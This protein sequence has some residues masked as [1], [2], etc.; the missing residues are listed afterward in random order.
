V[1]DPFFG[2]AGAGP[3]STQTTL[4]RGQLLRPFAEFQNVYM[5]STAA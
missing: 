3:Y 4:P 1:P 5:Q 2:V